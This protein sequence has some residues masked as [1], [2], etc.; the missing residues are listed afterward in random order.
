MT[1]LVIVVNTYFMVKPRKMEQVNTYFIQEIERGGRRG[2][3]GRGGRRGRNKS[4]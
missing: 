3:G 4:F 1:Q 2:R